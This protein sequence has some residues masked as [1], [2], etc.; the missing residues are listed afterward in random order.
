LLLL[1]V[2]ENLHN[3]WEDGAKSRELMTVHTL[4]ALVSDF[5]RGAKQSLN[6]NPQ[7]NLKDAQ[8]KGLR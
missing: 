8:S 5:Q 2:E 7:P 4:H 1:N 3:A 6:M